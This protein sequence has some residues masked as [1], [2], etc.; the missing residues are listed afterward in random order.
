MV[1]A[2]NSFEKFSLYFIFDSGLICVDAG[3]AAAVGIDAGNAAEVGI[4][5]D[6]EV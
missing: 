2:I 3:N 6:I 4:D 1:L 5:V